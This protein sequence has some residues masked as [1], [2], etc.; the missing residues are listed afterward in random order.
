MN[1]W[2][3]YQSSSVA[4]EEAPPWTKYA[5]PAPVDTNLLKENANSLDYKMAIAGAKQ[6]ESLPQYAGRFVKEGA[7]PAL[8]ATAGTAIGGVPGAMAGAALGETISQHVGLTPAGSVI[9]E[10]NKPDI[11]R[12]AITGAM[13]GVVPLALAGGKRLYDTGKSLVEPFY[14]KGQEAIVGRALRTASGGQVD[15]VVNALMNAKQIVPGSQPTAGQAANN[16]GIASMERA[17]SSVDPTVTVAF[18]AREA[19]QNE[20]RVNA[21][22][23]IAGTDA[24]RAFA[25]QMRKTSTAPLLNKLAQ[26]TASV[27]AQ[28]TVNLIDSMLE[29]YAGRPKLTNA[30]NAVKTSLFNESGALNSKPIQLYQGARTGITD[31]LAEKAGD[32]SKA[33]EAISRQLVTVMKSLDHQIGKVEKSYPA[34]MHDYSAM[35]K[36]INRLDAGRTILDKS[37]DRLTGDNLRPE[38]FGAALSDKTA[39]Q[40]TGFKRATLEGTMTPGQM[41]TLNSVRD[42]VARAVAAQKSAGTVGSDTVKKLAY[43]NLIDRAGVPTFLREFAPTQVAGNIM[44]RGAD[45][46]YGSANREISQQLAMTLLDPRKAAQVMQQAAPSRYDAIIAELMKK[47]TPMTGAA[48]AQLTNEGQR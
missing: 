37:T 42:D 45:A 32:G 41:D 14:K 12:V 47:G 17:A 21:L 20:A 33:N 31:L 7:L 9:P 23:G 40:A 26:S 38:S 1:P 24:D 15:D 36:P 18:N 16:A 11:G 25:E 35:S 3:K 2:E 28:P 43:S 39:Q 8:G 27:D 10:A 13:Q 30:L 5:G 34:F 48:A 44:A 29:R 22:R 19:A 6:A 46:A 4:T